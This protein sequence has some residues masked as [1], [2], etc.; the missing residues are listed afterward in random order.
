MKII[1]RNEIK[2]C[3]LFKFL[4]TFNYVE[5]IDLYMFN[6]NTKY[7]LQQQ[8]SIEAYKIKE[9]LNLKKDFYIINIKEDVYKENNQDKYVVCTTV[10]GEDYFEINTQYSYGKMHKEDKEKLML[11][12]LSK[13]LK[14]I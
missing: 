3:N 12:S 7:T 2:E 1:I 5:C 13:A 11:K 8:T 4:S 10:I 9:I 14:N 6:K